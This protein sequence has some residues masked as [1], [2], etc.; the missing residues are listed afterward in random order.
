MDLTF[1]LWNIILKKLNIIDLYNISLTGKFFNNLSTKFIEEKF[2][3]Y[4]DKY[5]KKCV[6]SWKESVLRDKYTNDFYNEYLG[7]SRTMKDCFLKDITSTKDNNNLYSIIDHICNNNLKK[8]WMSDI[9][10][11]LFVFILREWFDCKEYLLKKLILDHR[12]NFKER[13]RNI[14]KY[15]M[16]FLNKHSEYLM[17][18]LNSEQLKTIK[19]LP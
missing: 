15:N 3:L 13:F 17:S 14:D 10:P 9:Y 16:F 1:D 7:L 11:K 5:V 19:T 8:K 4:K 6:I 2:K 18:G 12:V